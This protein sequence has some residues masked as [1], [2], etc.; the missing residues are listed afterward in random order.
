MKQR[1][2][3][4]TSVIGGCLDVEFQ[5]PSVRLFEKFRSGEAIVVLSDLTLLELA[6]A[7]RK[8]RDLLK[9]IP[10]KY[11]EYIGLTAEAKELAELY[12]SEGVLGPGKRIDAQQFAIATISR[13]NVLVSWNFRHIVNLERIRGYNSINVREGYAVLE[14]RSPREVFVDEE[15]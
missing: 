7:P 14:I 4:D 13:V 15:S 8:V 3:T 2:Y 12:R 11:R 1:V 6:N 10:E 9:R 5:A